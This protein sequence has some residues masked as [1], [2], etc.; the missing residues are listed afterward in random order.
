[1]MLRTLVSGAC[2][3]VLLGWLHAPPA[4]AAEPAAA[5]GLPHAFFAF[6]NG[7]GRGVL[8]PEEQAKMLDELGYAGIGYT[9]TQGIPQMLAALDARGLKMFSTYVG[10]TIGPDGPAYAAGLPAAIEQLKGRETMIWLTVRG[11]AADGDQQAVRIVREV[12]DLAAKAGL[13]V[14]LYPHVGFFVATVEDSVR[15]AQK[16]DRP[17]V[18]A[19]FNLCHWLKAGD[20]A[21]MQRRMEQVLPH[22]FLVSI[23]GADH[24]GGWDRLIQTLDR[25]EFDVYRFVTAL[26]DLGY[27]GPIG[28]QCYNVRGDRR[29]NLQRSI[30]AW[31][32]FCKKRAEEVRRAEEIGRVEDVRPAEEEE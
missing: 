21:N 10:A 11:Q 8:P 5:P 18:G 13:K 12:G 26:H 7:T 14:A 15:I 32:G 9:G 2:G 1:M 17:N 4:R 28:L 6:D 25:G 31:N 22:L 20:E 30:D 16:V 19:S 23:N 3:I 27:E 24:E 29:D